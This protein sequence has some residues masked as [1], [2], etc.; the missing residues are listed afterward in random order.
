MLLSNQPIG[1]FPRERGDLLAKE[2]ASNSP[3]WREV[4]ACPTEKKRAFLI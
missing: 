3:L 2:S 1:L 4:G